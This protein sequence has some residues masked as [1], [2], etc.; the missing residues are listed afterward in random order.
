[1]EFAQVKLGYGGLGLA[2]SVRVAQPALQC[3]E[4]RSPATLIEHLFHTDGER[5]HHLQTLNAEILKRLHEYEHYAS[6]L[7]Y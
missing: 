3:N 7:G 5:H 2:D 4:K 6:N 1:V